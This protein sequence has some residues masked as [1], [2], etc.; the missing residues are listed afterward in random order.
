MFLKVDYTGPASRQHL[1]N[2][3]DEVTIV[4]FDGL[5]TMI[6]VER[7]GI[8]AWLHPEDLTSEKPSNDKDKEDNTPAEVIS[9]SPKGVQRVRSY[10][11]R[12]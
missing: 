9:Q 11:R 8:R 3:G 4:P 12:R 6:L 1:G 2:R 5:N 7:N 10:K